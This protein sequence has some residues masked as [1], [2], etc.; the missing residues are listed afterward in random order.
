[1]NAAALIAALPFGAVVGSF[2]ATAGLRWARGEQA[3]SGR[4]RCDAC[5]APLGFGATVPIISFVSLGGACDDCRAPIHPGHFAG[6]VLGAGLAMASV[7]LLP[8]A[9]ALAAA[10]LGLVLIA[11]AVA[12]T[13]SRRLPDLASAAAAILGLG[14]ALARGPA[15]LLAGLAAATLT[16]GALFLLRRGFTARRGDPGLGLGDV[17]LAAAL[18]LWLGA[19]TPWAMALAGLTGLVQVRLVKP[20][21]GRIAFGPVLAASGWVVGLALQA[22]LFGDLMP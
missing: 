10:A 8:T 15:A 4:S 13:A 5:A 18:A 2:A 11:A 9:P 17:K 20:A 3:L 12:D 22:G 16:G 7:A 21:D 1:M 6:E 14:L 19:A